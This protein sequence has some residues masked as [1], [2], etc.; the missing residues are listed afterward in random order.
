MVTLSAVTV[1]W[2]SLQAPQSED[3][4]S[5]VFAIKFDTLATKEE[6]QNKQHSRERSHLDLT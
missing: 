3:D 6:K 2:G 4:T 5:L 1:S